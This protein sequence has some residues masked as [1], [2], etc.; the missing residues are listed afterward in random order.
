MLELGIASL[1]WGS[2]F[3]SFGVFILK[4]CKGLQILFYLMQIK[5]VLCVICFDSFLIH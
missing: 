4:S 5:H 2:D 1:G 3:W